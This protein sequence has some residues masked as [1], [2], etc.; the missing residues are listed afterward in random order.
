MNVASSMPAEFKLAV[1]QLSAVTLRDEVQVTHISSPGS[2]AA[3]SHA[4]AADVH[5]GIDD[6]AGG[7]GRF[8]LLYDPEQAEA[9]GGSFR[10]VC[11]A[12]GPLDSEIETDPYLAK[13][14]WSWL[15][16]SLDSRGASYIKPSGTT[17]RVVS[18]GFGDLAG[19]PD[20][21]HIELRASWTPVGHDFTGQLEAWGD[22]L[23]HLAGLPPAS[24]AVM[25]HSRV[26][27]RG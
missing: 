26:Q 10:V 22:L 13:V 21:A 11:Y 19:G 4:F 14:I 17:T 6:E 24:G 7:T 16:D 12:Q 1:D 23:C 27:G 3:Y 18:Q 2:I 20:A 8:I 5:T 15:V 25:L 9:W